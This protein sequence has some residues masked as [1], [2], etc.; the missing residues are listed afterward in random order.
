MGIRKKMCS[1]KHKRVPGNIILELKLVLKKI[2]RLRGGLILKKKASPQSKT[3][4]KLQPEKG[5]GPRDF[6]L[7][8]SSYTP[9][10]LQYDLWRAGFTTSWQLNLVVSSTWCWLKEARLKRGCGTFLHS[11]WGQGCIRVVSAWGPLKATVWRC[12]SETRIALEMHWHGNPCQSHG[13]LPRS[14]TDSGVLSR[15]EI[16][17]RKAEQ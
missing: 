8:K 10:P 5:K 13:F 11:Y 17:G 9:K 2:R 16:V 7:L 15:R 14:A 4:A 12:E 6:L 3:P 1:L